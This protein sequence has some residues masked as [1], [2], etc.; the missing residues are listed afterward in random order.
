M[1]SFLENWHKLNETWRLKSY[2][3][4]KS[5][6]GSAGSGS[7]H[8]TDLFMKIVKVKFLYFFESEED[9]YE[10]WHLC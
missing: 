8:A 6:D 7:P 1:W 2:K 10:T 9:L 5:K 4:P 3:F